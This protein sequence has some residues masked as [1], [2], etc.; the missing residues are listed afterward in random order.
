[1]NSDTL[2]KRYHLIDELR[3]FLVLCMVFYHA[4]YLMAFSF[5]FPIGLTLFNF[6]TPL[7]P[8]FAAS[9]I[10]L[11]G[12][13]SFLTRS[14]FTRGIKLLAVALTV[15]IV[16]VYI[17]P[18]FH[19]TGFEIYFGVLHL[20]SVGMLIVALIKPLILKIPTVLGLIISLFIFFLTYNTQSGFW[21][22]GSFAY[23]LPE[24]LYENNLFF[25]GFFNNTF[26]SADY[27]PLLPWLFMFLAGAFIGTLHT[28]GKFPKFLEKSYLPP[29]KFIG[30][31]ALIIYIAHQP[32][33]WGILY[34]IRMVF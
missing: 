18:L 31:N 34:L 29:L 27:F 28:R 25:L 8:F 14:N 12:V 30:K 19:F 13:C 5:G 9:F 23:Q 15:T 3:G 16:T 22:F 21:G 17:F 11:S 1:M 4:F 6:F 20:L 33:V 24:K 26:W 7:E 32:I 2:K 10:F